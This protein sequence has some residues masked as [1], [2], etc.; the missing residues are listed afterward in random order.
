MKKCL[1]V[2]IL[3]LCCL[4]TTNAD[5][6]GIR[7]YDE[8]GREFC[9]YA[10]SGQF[11]FSYYSDD[12]ISRDF[13]GRVSQVGNTFISY[14][15]DGQVSRIG[16]V[17]MSYNYDGYLQRVGNLFIYYDYYGNIQRTSGHVY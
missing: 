13:N 12:Y 9:V 1:L 4:T 6:L 11:T 7:F 16:N 17:F 2:L 5:S 14:N 10:P 3:A 8:E 15:Y